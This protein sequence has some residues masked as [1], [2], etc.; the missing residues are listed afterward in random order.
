MNTQQQR[1]TWLW[2]KCAKLHK[3]EKNPWFHD[4]LSNLGSRAYCCM[5]NSTLKTCNK[6]VL[7]FIHRSEIQWPCQASSVALD[8]KQGMPCSGIFASSGLAGT[9]PQSQYH[10]S[11]FPPSP[12]SKQLRAAGELEGGLV[13]LSRAGN[14]SIRPS[15]GCQ[16]DSLAGRR[17][18]SRAGAQQPRSSTAK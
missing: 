9:R 11:N 17:R 12:S 15:G 18:P 8:L 16:N 14:S 4:I 2:H 1:L 5:H 3:R 13:T 6:M 7:I 10:G